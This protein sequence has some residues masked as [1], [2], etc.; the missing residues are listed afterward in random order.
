MGDDD[1][2]AIAISDRNVV[3]RDIIVRR[4]DLNPPT[5]D[6]DDLVMRL[7]LPRRLFVRLAIDDIIDGDDEAVVSI[8]IIIYLFG[9]DNRYIPIWLIDFF[10]P[11]AS[12][13]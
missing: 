13:I 7:L 6:E 9:D 11:L 4:C 3:V 12:N 2:D 8:S 10:L 1:D 5:G